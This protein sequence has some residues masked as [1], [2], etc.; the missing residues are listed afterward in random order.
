VFGVLLVILIQIIFLEIVYEH[1]DSTGFII[2]TRSFITVFAT[3][4]CAQLLIDKYKS[5][6]LKVF[7]NI[8]IICVII[9]GLVL[10][11]TFL[12]TDFRDLMSVFFYRDINSE[13]IHL[14]KL[15][16]PG[17]VATGGDGLS[18][19]HALLSVV[20]LMGTY[21]FYSNSRYLNFLVAILSICMI[22]TT[23][24]G[25]SGLYMGIIFFVAIIVTRNCN[26]QIRK[27]I[28]SV[29]VFTIAILLP[30]FIFRQEIGFLG[31]SLL[32]S[33]GYEY[34]L[35]RL[36]RGFIDYQGSGQFTNDT[37][38]V[39]LTDMV[40]IPSEPLRFLVG[41]NDFGQ[42]VRSTIYTDVGYFRMWHGIG[43]FGLIVFL[44]GI[45]IFPVIYTYRAMRTVRRVT[46]DRFSFGF[47]VALYQLLLFVFVFGLIGNYKIFFLSTRIYLFMFFILFILVQY[48]YQTLRAKQLQ[49]KYTGEVC[50]A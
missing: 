16:T 14:I 9:Q 37:I 33:Y 27:K 35:V 41:N 15:R 1:G 36:L 11:F 28:L 6:S 31:Q 42:Q 30:I 21:I 43:L 7:V 24:S 5:G 23:F 2:I 45:F 38:S 32:D 19:N 40:I 26:F 4:A 46:K 18:M 48:Q 10:W 49:Y 44:A 12:S 8:I 29:F 39:L 25:Q 13:S 47:V 3:L 50:V 20:G 34:P 22:A 17:F